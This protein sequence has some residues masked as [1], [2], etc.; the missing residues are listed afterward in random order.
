MTAARTPEP[1][2][3]AERAYEIWEAEGRPHGRDRAHWDRAEQELTAD[4]PDA[5]SR[6][7]AAAEV[8]TEAPAAKKPA[9]A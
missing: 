7:A 2:N 8:A 4:A 3:V 1:R 5:T 6:P 9:E